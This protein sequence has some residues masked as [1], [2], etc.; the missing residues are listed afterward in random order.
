MNSCNFRLHLVAPGATVNAWSVNPRR[1]SRSILS[2]RVRLDT[3]FTSGHISVRPRLSIAMPLVYTQ[4]S[5]PPCVRARA[6]VYVIDHA[7]PTY[8]CAF[9]RPSVWTSASRAVSYGAADR[10]MHSRRTEKDQIPWESNGNP[11]HLTP[12]HSSDRKGLNYWNI[13]ATGH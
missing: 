4:P 9:A 3:S 1:P 13:D 5:F 11:L 12:L 7:C 8:T 10:V 6:C 2:R